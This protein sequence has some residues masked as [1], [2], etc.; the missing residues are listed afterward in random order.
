MLKE[1]APLTRKA[2]HRFICGFWGITF[3]HLPYANKND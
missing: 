1:T 2:L 3:L